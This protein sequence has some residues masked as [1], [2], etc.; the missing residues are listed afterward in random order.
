[1]KSKHFA[2]VK[3]HGAE[4]V[5]RSNRRNEMILLTA[6]PTRRGATRS[7]SFGDNSSVGGGGCTDVRRIHNIETLRKTAEH[8]Y[9]P[10]VLVGIDGN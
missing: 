7:E 3:V 10:V 2:A 8:T 6:Y 9:A 1:M 4:V 5:F